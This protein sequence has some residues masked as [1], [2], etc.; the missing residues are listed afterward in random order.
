MHVHNLLSSASSSSFGEDMIGTAESISEVGTVA[1]VYS[2][3]IGRKDSA[4]L[5]HRVVSHAMVVQAE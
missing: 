3:R 5:P 1:G 4:G 2:I